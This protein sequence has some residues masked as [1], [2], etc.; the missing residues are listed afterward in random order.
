MCAFFNWTFL[1]PLKSSLGGSLSVSS[2]ISVE[3]SLECTG[4]DTGGRALC[5]IA[6]RGG[7]GGASPQVGGEGTPTLVDWG[8]ALRRLGDRTSAWD[9][10]TG[11]GTGDRDLAQLL[12]DGE[13]GIGEDSHAFCWLGEEAWCCWSGWF[14]VEVGETGGIT[15]IPWA[16]FPLE[17]AE[18]AERILSHH[19]LSACHLMAL[20]K[21]G[22]FCRY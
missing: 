21:H 18:W 17:A 19:L 22:M 6:G 11:S 14:F 20:S 9:L 4:D 10:L 16:V 7:G 13:T 1:I 8:G 2:K 5:P 15:C 12:V 3:V